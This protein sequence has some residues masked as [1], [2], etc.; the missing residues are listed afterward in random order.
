MR[1][2]RPEVSRQK[3]AKFDPA[4]PDLALAPARP[5]HIHLMPGCNDQPKLVIKR[6]PRQKTLA[7]QFGIDPPNSKIDWAR[8]EAGQKNDDSFP[9]RSMRRTE[10]RPA[11]IFVIRQYS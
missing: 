9:N 7:G 11:V 8:F 3:R 5:R 4:P 6:N 1:A 10:G 2:E